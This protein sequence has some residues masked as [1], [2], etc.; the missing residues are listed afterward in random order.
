MARRVRSMALSGVIAI[1]GSLYAV[2]IAATM[3][4]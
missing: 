2:A 4:P 3:G 1:L